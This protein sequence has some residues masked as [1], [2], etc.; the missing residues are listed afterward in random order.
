M[1]ILLQMLVQVNIQ[2]L[3][4]DA[5]VIPELKRVNDLHNMLLLLWLIIIQCFQDINLNLSLSVELFVVPQNFQSH[6]LFLFM[7]ET[8]EDYTKRS[9]PED[10]LN[11]IPII[12]VLSNFE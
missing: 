4:R 12:N 10:M 5:N 11:L 9:F 3:K 2:K 8:L 6:V 7:V 1:I